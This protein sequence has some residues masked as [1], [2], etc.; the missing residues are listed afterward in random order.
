MV[1]RERQ[2]QM[3]HKPKN[4]GWRKFKS[5]EARHHW[6]TRRH[7]GNCM[8][9]CGLFRLERDLKIDDTLPVCLRCETWLSLYGIEDPAPPQ[10]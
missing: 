5:G 4:I 10:K 9:A 6:R 2:N 8:S 7:M 1:E 3:N